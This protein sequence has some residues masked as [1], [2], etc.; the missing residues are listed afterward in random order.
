MCVFFLPPPDHLTRCSTALHTVR[1]CVCVCVQG[2]TFAVV[3]TDKCPVDGKIN[4]R[5]IQTESVEPLSSATST[6]L[7]K[8][9]HPALCC[10]LPVP[11][12]FPAL[13]T[14]SFCYSEHTEHSPCHSPVAY[15]KRSYP[16]SSLP[17][18]GAI[19]HG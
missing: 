16:L 15:S 7:F 19:N 2:D 5:Q 11:S 10:I 4:G 14:S 17:L 1:V 9:M 3:N 12:V 13:F 8:H 6:H 18:N